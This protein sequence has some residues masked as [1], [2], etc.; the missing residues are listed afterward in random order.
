MRILLLLV[1]IGVPLA[2]IAV[3]IKVG[4]IIG[5]AATIALVVL[6]AIVGV[7]LLRQQG[8]AVLARAQAALDAGEL[9]VDSVIDGVCLLLAGA[10]LLTPGLLTDVAGFLLLIPAF[11]RGLARWVLTKIRES[12]RF[13]VHV[14]GTHRPG[15]GGSVIDGDYSR[16]EETAPADKTDDE[17]RPRGDAKRS[18]WRP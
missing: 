8:L 1:F 7:A 6:T 2:E 10:F 5:I 17:T 13:E 18:P 12:D 15:N 9:P 11:R 3:F 14:S 16:V 4:E